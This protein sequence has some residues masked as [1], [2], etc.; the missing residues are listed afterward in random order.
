MPEYVTTKIAKA[1]YGVSSSTLRRWMDTNKIEAIRSPGGQR[2]YHLELKSDPSIAKAS[3]I[4]VRVSSTKQRDDLER[5]KAYM[6]EQFPAFEVVSDIGSGLNFKRKGLLSLL[7]RAK[8]GNIKQVVVASK[9]RLCRFGYEFLEWFFDSCDTE[10]VVL[11]HDDHS[12]ESELGD[13]ILS[14][15]Q[16]FCC[17]RNGRRRYARKTNAHAKDQAEPDHEAESAVASVQ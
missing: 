3:V 6:L 11:E 8:G 14:I 4:Y 15:V 9:D 16:V 1:H 13:D 7:E 12:P 17:R 10:F 5:Q 2:L